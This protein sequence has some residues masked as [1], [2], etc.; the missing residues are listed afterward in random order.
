MDVAR[1]E[2][3]EATLVHN[4]LLPM[5]EPPLE[6][7]ER[8]DNISAVRKTLFG[9]LEFHQRPGVIAQPVIAIIAKSKMNLWQVRIEREGAIEGILGCRQ[10]RWAWIRPYPVT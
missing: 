6:I 5:P 8:F 2:L 3:N 10:P 7:S 1:I 4:C 9:L